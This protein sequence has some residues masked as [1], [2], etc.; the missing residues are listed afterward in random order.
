MLNPVGSS[1]QSS[2]VS[3][4][5]TI[6]WK[7]PVENVSLSDMSDLLVD[8]Y[9]Y[10]KDNVRRNITSTRFHPLLHGDTLNASVKFT[11]ASYP[12][13]N[14]LWMEVNPR[15]DQPEQYHFNNYARIDFN[16]NR[17]VTNPILDVTFYGQHILNG[18]IVSAKP[19]IL[20]K[21][22]D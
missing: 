13:L 14:S 19:Q 9:L 10:D 11:T 16:V 15:N 7:M 20:I 18:D 2:N 3:Q 5:D 12:G 4:G 1:F 21:L 17:D 22:K 8:Y 6:H